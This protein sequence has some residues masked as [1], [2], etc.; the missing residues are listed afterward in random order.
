ME[1]FKRKMKLDNKTTEEL[2]K[3]REEIESDPANKNTDGGIYLYTVKARKKLDAI[4]EA[5]TEN[6]RQAKVA[7]GELINTAG[8]SGRQANRRR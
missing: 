4:T 8:Y 7:R 5:I 3:L 2:L 1:P 6:L